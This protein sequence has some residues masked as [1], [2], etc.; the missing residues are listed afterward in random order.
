MKITN[1]ELPQNLCF[2]CDSE[3]FSGV[4][5]I[6]RKVC[7]DIDRVFG[8]KPALSHSLADV[9]QDAV[10]FGTAGKSP[11]LDSLEKSSR[12]DLSGIRGKRE[13][14]GFFVMEQPS[15]AF[16]AVQNA[17]VIAGSDKRGTIYG[18]FHISELLGVS[19]L[20]DFADVVPAKKE[21]MEFTA[22]HNMISREPSVKYRGFFINDE[23]PA[24]GNWSL[25]RFGGP[26]ALCYE[27]IFE[28][29]LRLK[30]NYLWPAMWSAVFSWDGPGLKNAE[31]ADEYGVVMGTSHHEP[32]CR[33]GEEHRFYRRTTQEYGSEW[34]FQRNRDGVTRFWRDGL[35]RNRRFENIYTVGMR[36]EADTAI[37]GR[38]A[39]L[40]DNIDLLKDV[41]RTQYELM[42]EEVNPDLEKIPRMLVMFSEVDKFYFGNEE[43]QGLKDTD[44]LDGVT[45]MMTDD[46]YGV[47]RALPDES[48]RAH[49]GGLGLYYHFDFH[50]GPHCYEW[51]NE[52]YLPKAW[53]Q[54]SAAYDWG[55]RDVWIV[56]AGD[57]GLLEFP[58]N[59]FMDMAYDFEKY[60]SSAPN[61]T[62]Q[63][64]HDWLQ[65]HFASYF[66]ASD[67]KQMEELV[68]DYTFLTNRCK[69]EVMNERIYDA[70][71][72]G[73]AD[74]LLAKAEGIIQSAGELLSRCPAPIEGAFWEL[75]YYSAAGSANVYRIWIACA[76][77]QLYAR[78]NRVEANDWADK[79]AAY[80]DF[81]SKLT[82]S[83]HAVD[84]G[85]FYGFGL[86]EH[87]GFGHWNDEDDK[88]PILMR[89]FPSKKPRLIVNPTDREEYLVGTDYSEKEMVI[90]AFMNPACEECK[91]DL[92]PSNEEPIPYTAATESAWLSLSH[93]K[94]TAL[95]RHDTLTVGID[96]SLLAR[97]G[98]T[99]TGTVRIDTAFSHIQLHFPARNAES[100]PQATAENTYFESQGYISILADKYAA[101]HGAA[102]YA[103]VHL[104]GYGRTASAMKVLPA[105]HRPFTLDGADIPWLEYCFCAETEGAYTAE[106]YFSPTNPPL[107]DNVMEYACSLNGEEP[108]VLNMVD[109]QTFV[110]YFSSEWAYGAEYN[111]QKRKATV[112]CRKGMNT[113]RFFALCPTLILEKIV[114]FP[115]GK[116][117]A[118]SYLGPAESFRCSLALDTMSCRRT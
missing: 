19:P 71:H 33:A 76:K 75:V 101:K 5:K 30:G 42:K 27:H 111:I 103:F 93:K 64:T 66:S 99:A 48:M 45:I 85:R 108:R 110:T 20:V 38:E 28:L 107:I 9:R 114:L 80:L 87:I 118:A 62:K 3:A 105:C 68:Q 70:T 12:I 95:H 61:S 116:P 31:L 44:L 8:F 74:A 83:Y 113:L 89:I 21:C 57:V 94:G 117:P 92:A 84:G 109:K 100:L 39:T 96:R 22:A 98:G 49:K 16:P 6:S 11:L 65:K 102:P 4:Q 112:S 1:L 82:D 91:V 79:V 69:P 60:G 77:N 51:V 53:E 13:V 7:T 52:N 36:G 59:Y 40:K 25:K 34:N 17:I 29:L 81:D 2:V 50:G 67:M 37:L 58:L 18:L 90:D 46:N 88:K 32:C 115:E 54:L 35:R 26:N 14:F 97:A 10:I 72:Y 56:N 104:E 106:F 23:W 86:S 63:W 41:L 24:F 15:A 47:L 43:T 73:E 78:Q 55:I